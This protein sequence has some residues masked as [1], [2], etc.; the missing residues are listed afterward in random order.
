MIAK[1]RISFI[2][3]FHLTSSLENRTREIEKRGKVNFV[4]CTYFNWANFQTASSTFPF[5]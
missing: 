2:Y 5:L 1:K 4:P 3:K